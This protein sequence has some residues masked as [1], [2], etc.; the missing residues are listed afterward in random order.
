[1]HVVYSTSTLDPF[2]SVKDNNVE[3]LN[4]K[5]KERNPVNTLPSRVPD[6]SMPCLVRK[7]N[8]KKK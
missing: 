6:P 8:E 5:K 3:P 7:K 4:K 2:S 1:M